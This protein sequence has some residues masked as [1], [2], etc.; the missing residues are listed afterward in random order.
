[1]PEGKNDNVQ[2]VEHESVC[3]DVFPPAEGSSSQQLSVQTLPPE[4][5]P[6]MHQR[7]L[8]QEVEIQLSNF[9]NVTHIIS[10]RFCIFVSIFIDTNLSN[11]EEKQH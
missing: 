1:M 9:V 11:R 2:T 3:S 10:L 8:G 6:T 7:T 4:R 5:N